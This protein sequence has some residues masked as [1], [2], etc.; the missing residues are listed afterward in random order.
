VRAQPDNNHRNSWAIVITA[1]LLLAIPS[2]AGCGS[3]E[4]TSLWRDRDITVDGLDTEWDN[5]RVYL[6]DAKS[7]V[8]VLNDEDFIYISL[9]TADRAIRRQIM[10]RGFTL[11]FDPHGGKNEAFGLHYPLGMLESTGL[12]WAGREAADRDTEELSKDMR[13]AFARATTEIEIIGPDENERQRVKVATLEGIEIKV[14][15]TDDRLVY[16]LKVPIASSETHPFAIGAQPGAEIRIGLT[17]PEIDREQMRER[18]GRGGRGMPPG[19]GIGRGGGMRGG[20]MRGERRPEPPKPLDVW[21]KV[22]L[23]NG[24]SVQ[25]VE[26]DSDH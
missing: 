12:P 10:G 11:W 3:L 24:T 6:D 18:V 16:E 17:T 19:G 8:A 13:E 4:L 2:F 23:S 1:A 15:V 9:V 22:Q 14:D 25:A 5:T 20:G 26:S 7:S 21:A